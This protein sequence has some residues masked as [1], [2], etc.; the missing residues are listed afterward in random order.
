[1]SPA[2]SQSA[3]SISAWKMVMASDVYL[4]PLKASA[5]FS[6]LPELPS[7]FRL[8]VGTEASHRRKQQ[9]VKGSHCA[10]PTLEVEGINQ[11]LSAQLRA[12]SSNGCEQ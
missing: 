6:R 12:L 5:S 8:C 3:Y 11:G 10:S 4:H 7:A 1:M 2:E 9:G